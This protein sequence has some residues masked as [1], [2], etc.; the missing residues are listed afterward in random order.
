MRRAISAKCNDEAKLAKRRR[1][2]P[3]AEINQLHNEDD[4]NSQNDD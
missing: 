2:A 4:G 3:R 1:T